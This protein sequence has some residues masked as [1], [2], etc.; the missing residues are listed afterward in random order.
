MPRKQ[1]LTPTAEAVVAQMQGAM[2]RTQELSSAAQV[3]QEKINKARKK[4]E[5]Q[6]FVARLPWL[7]TGRVK[8]SARHIDYLVQKGIIAPFQPPSKY[9]YVK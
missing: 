4:L 2:E 9:A 1:K 3:A 8:R 7:I 5:K 6:R